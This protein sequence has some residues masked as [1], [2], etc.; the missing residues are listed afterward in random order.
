MHNELSR[1][2]WLGMAWLRGG[3]RRRRRRY[4]AMVVFLAGIMMGPGSPADTLAGADASASANNASIAPGCPAVASKGPQ[5]WPGQQAWQRLER[6]GYRLGELRVVVDDVYVGDALAWY[7]RLANTLHIDTRSKVI[8]SLL[9]VE[10]GQAVEARRIY[11]SERALRARRFL[12]S[13]RITPRRCRDGRVD[14]VIRVRDAWTL[15]AGASVGSSGG[16]TATSAGFQDENFLGSATTVGLDWSRTPERTTRE[17]G[18]FD[19]A[20]LSSGW[21]LELGYSDRSD[22]RRSAAA[23][24]YPYRTFDQRWSLLAEGADTAKTVSFDQAGETAYRT[25][26]RRVSRRLEVRRLIT[27]SGNSGW[28]GGVGWHRDRYRYEPLEVEDQ[29]LRPAPDLV[30]RDLSGPYLVLARFRDR[31]R[32]FRNLRS[33]GRTRDY[34]LGLGAE[35]TLGRYRDRIRG[36]DPFF[37]EFSLDYGTRLGARQLLLSRF[38]L[39]GRYSDERG[40]QAYYRSGSIDYYLPTSPRNTIVAHGEADWRDELDPEGELYLGGFDGLQ[41]YPNHFRVGDRRWL[42][43]LENRHVSDVVLFDTVQLGYTAYVEA[44][45]IRGLN[46]EWSQTLADIGVGLRLGSLRSSFGSV[47][48]LTV[49]TP[50]VDAGQAPDYEWI[51]GSS[52][53]F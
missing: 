38:E 17:I 7:Q 16:E 46:G 27:S 32:S 45:R 47:T 3:R 18:Y 36:N 15:Q 2:Q 40:R 50:L 24:A 39:S 11:E 30:E 43:H 49:A 21:T 29:R 14:A 34:N 9:T 8:R 31:Y 4:R 53:D 37:T 1:S 41:A 35:W 20:L 19:P 33:I 13:A 51:V 5:E 52:F 42:V 44:G 28:R 12:T 10:S 6:S 48:Y 25:R 23:L 26:L 22:G